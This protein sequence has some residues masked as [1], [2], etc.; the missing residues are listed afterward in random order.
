[1]SAIVNE[2][3]NKFPLF[4]KVREQLEHRALWL[5]LLVDEAEKHGLA[6]DEFAED[7]VKRC[8][9]YQGKEIIQASGTRSLKGLRKVLF[10]RSA[11]AIFEMKVI[12]STDEKLSIDFHYCP[13]VKAWQKQ[14]ASDE[15]IAHLCDIAMCGDR[16]IGEA[17]G[18]DLE[19]PKTIAKGDG[20]CE[21][22]YV[23]RP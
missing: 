2:A 3:K 20:C 5:Y 16:G 6:S 22:R 1:M 14:G 21:I 10:T 19:L 8:G 11:Q 15:K 7:A 4:V 23:R 12:E 17:H 13:L 18:V 9:L